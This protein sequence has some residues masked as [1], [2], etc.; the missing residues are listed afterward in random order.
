MKY[1]VAAVSYANTIPFLHGLAMPMLRDRVDV[2]VV[3]P[4]DCAAMLVRGE[5]EIALCPVGAFPTL[6]NPRILTDY[7]IGCDGPVRTVSI[8]SKKPLRELDCVV[9][10]P[11]SRTSNL[12]VQVLE[13][14]FWKIGLKFLSEAP[15]ISPDRIGHLHIGDKC[16]AM[17]DLYRYQTD[18]GAEWKRAT[19]LPFV[20]ACWTSLGEI[21][22]NFESVLN[23]AFR[24]GVDDIDRLIHGKAH[25]AME[26]RTY[27]KKHI[28]FHFTDDKRK[29]LD[30]FLILLSNLQTRGLVY[31]ENRSAGMKISKF[32]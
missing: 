14:E 5:V 28:S 3:P 4:A 21:D 15:E 16:F 13:R 25:D 10:S 12:L 6:V 19:G 31:E 18:L 22:V 2:H 29:A 8:F 20:F 30:H 9:L 24:A 26:L 32:G 11:E 27:L 17:E 7:C 1:R 23:Q